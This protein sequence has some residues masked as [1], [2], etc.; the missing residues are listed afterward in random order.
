[1][2]ELAL[3]LGKSGKVFGIDPWEKAMERTQLKIRVLNIKNAEVIKGVAREKKYP[4]LM[5]I[6]LTCLYRTME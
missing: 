3:R 2:I 6:T 4:P 5:T 1:M